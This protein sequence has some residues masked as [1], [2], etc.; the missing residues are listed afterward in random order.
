MPLELFSGNY[1]EL[2]LNDDPRYSVVDNS[3]W[4]MVSLLHKTLCKR[5]DEFI[6]V[7]FIFHFFYF[8]FLVSSCHYQIHHS[9]GSKPHGSFPI[10]ECN[11]SYFLGIYRDF[12]L[13]FSLFAI[14]NLPIESSCQGLLDHQECLGGVRSPFIMIF[15]EF[16]RETGSLN[17]IFGWTAS[18]ISSQD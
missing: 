13:D 16:K 15:K 8:Y 11:R 1:L 6:N 2:L 14:T 18:A 10:Y 3:C 4:L 12:N 5:W 9:I 7:L 17:L